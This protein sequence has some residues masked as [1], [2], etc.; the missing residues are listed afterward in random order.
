MATHRVLVTDKLAEEGLAQLRA[1]PSIELVVNT[2]LAADPTALRQALMEADGIAIRSG[3]QLTA[4]VL[5]GQTRLK[6]IVR[7]GVGVDNIDVAAASRRGIVVMNTPGGNT[8]STAEHT[9]ALLLS[10]ARNVPKANDSL[11][12]GKWDR[13]KFTGTQ[14][15]GKTLGV[16]GLGRVGL[17]VARRAQ[18]FGM[19]VVGF[20]P[21]LAADKALELGVESVARLDDIWGRCDFITLHTPM[22]TET[23]NLIG[24]REIA[25]MKPT[26]R[27]INCARGGL[28][29]EAAL[30]EALDNGKV[31]GAAIDVFEPEP[32]PAGHPLVGHPL[33]VVTPHLGASTE[34]AQ[35]SVA[36][37]AARLLSD[38]LTRGQVRFAVNMPSLDKAE[39]DDVRLYLNLAWRLGMLHSQ[40][41]RGTLKNAR[42]TFRGEVAHKNTKLITASFAAGLME[43]AM[44]QQVNLVNAIPLARER[45]IVIEER[46]AEAPAD[47]A[48]LIQTEVTTERKGYAAS[49]TLFGKQFLRLVRLGD[50]LLDAHLDGTLLI[51]THK[52]RP[53]LIGFIGRTLGDEGVNIAQMNVGREQQGGEAIGVVNLD[54]VPSSQALEAVRQ[55]PDII[56]L[57]VIK[58]PPQGAG[59]SW[60]GA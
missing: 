27:I 41:D 56:S 22:T 25:L 54:S 52:D 13:T 35:V 47:F 6:A 15:E 55:N 51:F 14:L 11:K 3:T 28:I 40:M 48:T 33:V 29:D 45:G 50:Y 36:V 58:L 31:A 59:P 38:F 21:F 60:L 46:S 57:S 34:E 5:E 39:L 2:K 16:I 1:E 8:I 53:G 49:G 7:A 43:A 17:T 44:E 10:L 32:P 23:R 9:M 37:E 42:I 20:D 26:V 19:T 30:A 12:A 4:E 18:G 24:P